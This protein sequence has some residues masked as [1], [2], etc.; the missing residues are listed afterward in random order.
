M[1][2]KQKRHHAPYRCPQPQ[3]REDQQ[4]AITE[5]LVNNI[6][7][8][9]SSSKPEPNTY[10][11]GAVFTAMVYAIRMLESEVAEHKKAHD[12]LSRQITALHKRIVT[13]ENR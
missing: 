13:L 6:A 9:L 3:R 5:D 11:V 8:I 7:E 10:D 4:S 1:C 2:E 12:H